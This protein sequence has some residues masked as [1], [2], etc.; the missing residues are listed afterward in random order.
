VLDVVDQLSRVKHQAELLTEQNEC[1]CSLGK[2]LEEAQAEVEQTKAEAALEKKKSDMELQGAN[3]SRLRSEKAR[4]EV[5]QQL[6]ALVCES[7]QKMHQSQMQIDAQ[8]QAQAEL[9]GHIVQKEEQLK[10]ARGIAYGKVEDADEDELQKASK[11]Y[12]EARQRSMDARMDPEKKVRA[13]VELQMAW[14]RLNALH[15]AREARYCATM[16]APSSQGNDGGPEVL[17][18]NAL[19]EI[20]RELGMIDKLTGFADTT[21]VEPYSDI[22]SVKRMMAELEQGVGSSTV[23]GPSS[24][25]ALQELSKGGP[26]VEAGAVAV[27]KALQQS[28]NKALLVKN[29]VRH[30]FWL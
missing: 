12:E 22:A 8:A 5:E 28:W 29:Q 11:I 4:A 13:E 21:A 15:S 2:R 3:E 25:M 19:R 20:E 26:M 23:T 16:T 6:E 7:S 30:H 14:D 17:I 24:H 18:H 27:S 9:Q 10:A 1:V